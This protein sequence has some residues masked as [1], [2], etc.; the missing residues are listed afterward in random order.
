MTN[1]RSGR[2]LA[3]EGGEGGEGQDVIA[4][5][6]EVGCGGGEFGFQGVA[7]GFTH[8]Q[9]M[10]SGKLNTLQYL[11][12]LAAQHGMLRANVDLLPGWCWESSSAGD[13][14]RLGAW[15]GVMSQSNGDA[16]L[17]ANQCEG[18]LLTAEHLG[19]RVAH[20]SRTLRRGRARLADTP[21]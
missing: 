18:D 7:A 5:V 6:A 1:K 21:R 10:S 16:D 11:S 2:D 3:G 17:Q 9:A 13:V 8:S 14:N 12:L 4:G 15:L 19:V 20:V